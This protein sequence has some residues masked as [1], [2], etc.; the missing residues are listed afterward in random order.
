ME[1]FP[2]TKFHPNPS[3]I[4]CYQPYQKLDR[5]VGGKHGFPINFIFLA[6]EAENEINRKLK[7]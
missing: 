7:I 1:L 6:K 4:F 2:N 5:E 3:S